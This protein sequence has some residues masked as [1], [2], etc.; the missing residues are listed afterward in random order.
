MA[1]RPTSRGNRHASHLQSRPARDRDLG[2]GSRAKKSGDAGGEPVDDA[3]APGR[4]VAALDALDSATIHRTVG[5]LPKREL[6]TLRGL[7]RV[8]AMLLRESDSAARVVQQRAG[9]MGRSER[10]DLALSLAAACNDETVTALGD[11]HKDPSVADMQ[12]VLDPIVERHGAPI[13]ALMMA[14]YVDAAA[15]CADA[16]AEILDTDPRFATAT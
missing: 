7:L 3:S 5:M 9:R 15:P 8:P 2:G 12:G 13:V 14:A 6:E 1:D 10:I 16:F 11:Q 4:V